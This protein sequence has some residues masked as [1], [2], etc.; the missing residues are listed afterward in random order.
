VQR[1]TK[2][3][4]LSALEC[5]ANAGF[6]GELFVQLLRSGRKSATAFVMATFGPIGQSFG[7]KV[8]AKRYPA[9]DFGEWLYDMTWVEMDNDW[10]LSSPVVIESE[11]KYHYAIKDQHR[12]DHDFQK[13]VQARADVRVWVSSAPNPDI[14]H[15]HIEACE[16]QA[17]MFAGAQSGDTYL[18]VINVWSNATPIIRRFAVDASQPSRTLE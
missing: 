3:E 10:L 13:L 17:S 14:A 9:A 4:I 2:D 12:V 8:G 1:P 6:G 7:F 18:F 16:L 11:W 5:A 15:R